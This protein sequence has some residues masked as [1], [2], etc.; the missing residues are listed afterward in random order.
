MGNKNTA[1]FRLFVLMLILVLRVVWKKSTRAMV[2]SLLV[3]Y[4][5]SLMFFSGL[6]NAL[7]I[8]LLPALLIVMV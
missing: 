3:S 1:L 4:G 5:I 6:P 8:Y 7:H 2:V